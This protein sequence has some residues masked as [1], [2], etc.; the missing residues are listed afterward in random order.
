MES[1]I[2][3]IQFIANLFT[4]VA[5][6]IAIYLFLFKRD[7]ISK[8]FQLLLNYSN[9][10][11]LSELKAKLESLNSYNVNDPEHL[12][13]VLNILHEIEGQINGNISLSTELKPIM[14][15]IF[16]YTSGRTVL[17]EAKKR[18]VVFELRECIRT[19][20]VS[21]YKNN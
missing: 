1:V 17:S 9:Q 6:G 21:S 11:T 13:E 10:L 4:I 18:S 14:G 8:A 16:E 15:K 3:G 7:K 12:E 19:V 20:D 5:S 2:S